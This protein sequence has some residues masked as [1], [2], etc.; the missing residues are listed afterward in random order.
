[1]ARVLLR[2]ALA[3]KQPLSAGLGLV[4]CVHWDL[5]CDIFYLAT[6]ATFSEV[7][8][9]KRC[10]AVVCQVLIRVSVLTLAHL[11]RDVARGAAGQG[12][13][14]VIVRR[15]RTIQFLMPSLRRSGHQGQH[16]KGV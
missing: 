3:L 8:T 16:R 15:Y 6:K 12:G 5:S 9:Y 13:V 11:Q 2:A 7:L 14:S 4:Q 10:L 1:M